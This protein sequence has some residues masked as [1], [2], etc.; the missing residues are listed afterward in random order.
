MLNKLYDRSLRFKILFLITLT[1]L[2][3]TASTLITTRIFLVDLAENQT[4]AKVQGDLNTG[5][6]IINEKYPGPWQLDDGKLYK[7]KQLMSGNHALIDY[8]SELTGST[9]TLFAENIRIATSILSETG[10]RVVGTEVS[11]EVADEVLKNGNEY[12]GRADIMGAP[13]QTA[14]TPLHNEEGE[15]VGMW[16]TGLDQDSLHRA[17]ATS[18][19]TIILIVAAITVVLLGIGYKFT[20]K[21]TTA[22]KQTATAADELAS[23]NFDGEKLT[24]I[25]RYSQR[26][27]EIGQVAQALTSMCDDL[28]FMVKEE[29]EI[30]ESLASSSQELS[31]NSEE[32]SASA[33][34]ISTAVQEV[35]SGAEEQ[36]AQIDETRE[37]MQDMNIGVNNIKQESEEM[38]LIAGQ[39][40]S[41]VT[42]GRKIMDEAMEGLIEAKETRDNT[43]ELAVE[44]VNL[45]D[46]IGDIIN[47]IKTIADQ[48]NLL[49]LNASIEAARAGQAGQGFNVVA[50]E[51]RDLSENTSDSTEDIT[52]L[53]NQVQNNI[54]N[55]KNEMEQAAKSM[56]ASGQKLEES[57]AKYKD[58]EK[59]TAKLN[60][61]IDVVE[62]SVH[63]MSEN[64]SEITMA[65]EEIAAVSKQASS[66]AEEVAAVS[67]QQSASTQEVVKASEELTEMTRGLNDITGQFN[68]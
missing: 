56:K 58:V 3:L 38:T 30:A 49:A 13:Y 6:E 32:M 29:V 19:R 26:G 51:I 9:A 39:A 48:T 27:D 63:N 12:H 18:F 37:N 52:S 4:A 20:V 67:E 11:A 45:S 62:K 68:I 50:E 36:T 22:L 47:F 15:I 8:I 16:Y 14:Y 41:T 34:E 65:I 53:I 55:M 57:N 31:A 24:T 1:M 46:E 21:I 35:A 42:A 59:L 7:G 28:K 64:S 54:K 25:S 60:Q 2:I 23:F 66:H 33:Q 17:V 5:Y 61:A 43:D 10:E 44:L 40:A